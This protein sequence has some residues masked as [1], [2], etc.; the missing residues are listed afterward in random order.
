MCVV[1]LVGVLGRGLEQDKRIR[2][3]HLVERRIA[4]RPTGEGRGVEPYEL[5]ATGTLRVPVCRR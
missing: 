3:C 1:L 2:L 5:R 4:Q